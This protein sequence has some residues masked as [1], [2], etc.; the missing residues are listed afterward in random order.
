MKKKLVIIINGA[1]TNGGELKSLYKR[2]LLN[3]D[4]FVYYPSLLP[5]SFSGDYFKKARI[6]DFKR[7][8]KE[9]LEIIDEDFED[10]YVVGYSLGASTAAIIASETDKVSKV[11][12]ISPVLKNPNFRKFLVGIT[13]SLG[14]S[15]NLTRIQKIFYNE[16]LYRF[17]LIPKIRLLTVEIYLRYSRKFI[18]R[19]KQKTL[20][21]ETLKDEVVKKSAIDWIIKVMPSK[22]ITR[23]SIDSSH[24]L[25]FDKDHRNEIFDSITD[26]LKED[27]K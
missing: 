8:I 15:E 14:D 6:R 27:Q 13:Q 3:E 26:F 23:F 25:F 5:G 21:I 24:F 7:F 18:K 11:V 2:L 17:A 22:D 4:Y 1:G 10:V 12:F 20:I 9:T 19:V 16:F